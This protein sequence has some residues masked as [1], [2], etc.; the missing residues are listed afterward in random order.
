MFLRVSTL[1]A[2]AVIGLSLAHQGWR[3]RL[4][5]FDLVP[6]ADEAQALL[7]EGHLP[8]K[9][10]LSGFAS[11]TPPGSVW[12]LA[13]G[14]AL[15]EDPRLY[16]VV[17]SGLLYVGTLVGVFALASVCAPQWL[18]LIAAAVWALSELGLFFAHS[19]W[20]RGHPFFFVW[21]VYLTLQWV[22]R[23]N[24]WYLA[25]AIITWSVGMFVFMEIAP[26]LLI[27]PAAW[28]LYRPPWRWRC[29]GSAGLVALLLWSPYLVF[30]KSRGFVD[31]RS[32]LFRQLIHPKPNADW[33]DPSLLPPEW[34]GAGQ[35]TGTGFI[36]RARWAVASLLE[37][38]PTMAIANFRSAVPGGWILVA[39]GVVGG[40]L[41][42]A[43]WAFQGISV[44]VFRTCGLL[45]IAAPIAVNEWT[46]RFA[47]PDGQLEAH[48]VSTLRA[49][50]LTALLLGV[51]LWLL[52]NQLHRLLKQS[53]ARLADDGCLDNLRII[54]LCLTL[55]WAV[56]LLASEG[57]RPERFW[58]L[59]SVQAVVL[60]AGLALLR[61]SAMRVALATCVLT[62]VAI[63]GVTVSRI[64]SWANDGWSGR[65]AAILG[66]I[67]S[68][69]QSMRGRDIQSA[70]IGYE[71]GF[72]RFMATFHG[73]DSRY[74][75]GKEFDFLLL[76]R[77][78]LT[79]TNGC[80]EG[81]SRADAY[82]IVAHPGTRFV[83]L[84]EA[85][86][87]GPGELGERFFVARDPDMRSIYSDE[88][89][90]VLAR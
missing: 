61:H 84:P 56:L 80:A 71:V 38:G 79:N 24:D 14:M 67:D 82:R 11:Y 70:A 51:G 72:D 1:C 46:A 20:P 23:R 2:V 78:G 37:F 50:G 52:A 3:S 62:A 58:W 83:T 21:M 35:T 28:W 47:S 22:R 44:H 12:L 40:L 4:L 77:H 66:A 88:F 63:N 16:E 39:T 54:A 36:N 57:Q 90:T 6:N 5:T 81:Q 73:A 48:S 55:P 86:G 68:L 32:Q 53:H 30:E 43:L 42:S 89:F 17:G 34:I 8:Q 10:T 33:C 85:T 60:T 87:L 49:Y 69:A 9:G 74:K 76:R 65:D 59:W 15:I 18:A 29:L 41:A 45:L 7:T 25:A 64:H 13:P 19:L 27:L 31:L 26:A 75:V